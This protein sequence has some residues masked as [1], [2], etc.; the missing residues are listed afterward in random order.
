MNRD[1]CDCCVPEWSPYPHEHLGPVPTSPPSREPIKGI[2]DDCAEIEEPP[3]LT[4]VSWQLP[5]MHTQIRPRCFTCKHFDMCQYK[6]D[7]LKTV[8]VLQRGLG[9]P[10]DENYRIAVE[11][12][13]I[14][15]FKGIVITGAEA[16]LPEEITFTGTSIKGKL[17]MAKFNGINYVNIVYMYKDYFILLELKY[18]KTTEL[19]EVESCKEAFYGDTYTI[20]QSSLEDIQLGLVDWRTHII[21]SKLPEHKLEMINT[22]HFSASLECD[23]YDWNR[24]SFD[25]SIEK[26][27]NAYP[28]GIPISDDDKTLYHIATFHIAQQEIPYSPYFQPESVKQVKPPVRR[29]DM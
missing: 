5:P 2:C 16:Y 9:S 23:L 25:K 8:T 21:E 26:L 29:G 7:Y 1:V 19:Y 4:P 14:P 27:L 13:K 3:V 22:T 18:N 15:D 17:F 12:G 11:V 24:L 20:T 6:K 28:N 10:T